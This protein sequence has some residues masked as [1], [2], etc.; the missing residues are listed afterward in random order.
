MK[1][2]GLHGTIAVILSPAAPRR[3]KARRRTPRE[4]AST[5]YHHPTRQARGGSFGV[6]RRDA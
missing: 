2:A 3:G 5:E 1:V 6:L 4:L